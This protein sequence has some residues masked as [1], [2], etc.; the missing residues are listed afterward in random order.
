[1]GK[2]CLCQLSKSIPSVISS[3]DIVSCTD[4]LAGPGRPCLLSPVN[5]RHLDDVGCTVVPTSYLTQKVGTWVLPAV[6]YLDTSQTR[7]HREGGTVLSN[8][9]KLLLASIGQWL[10]EKSREEPRSRSLGHCTPAPSRQ[11]Q[12]SSK[13]KSLC[14]LGRDSKRG[15]H[16]PAVFACCPA[17]RL[18]NTDEHLPTAIRPCWLLLAPQDPPRFCHV[19][20]RQDS[21]II[22]SPASAG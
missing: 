1:M 12:K 3:D 10:S 20:Y 22:T 4:S 13:L 6:L 14:E 2:C 16:H 11:P 7:P 15:S 9:G 21:I 19:Y 18:Q 5:G 8:L 17:H